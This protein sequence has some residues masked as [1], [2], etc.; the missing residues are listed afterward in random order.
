M[1]KQSFLVICIAACLVLSLVPGV[2][3]LGEEKGWITVYCN[4]EGASVYFDGSYMGAISGGSYTATVYT[5]AT[6][7]KTATVEKSGYTTATSAI[8]MPSTGQTTTIYTT[9]YPIVTPTPVQYGSIFVSSQPSGA[10]IYFNGDYRGL[11]PLTISD[12]WPG[13]YTIRAEKS[14]YQDYS[15]TAYVSSGTQSTVYCPLTALNTAGALY[16]I[17]TPSGSNVYLD[18]AY[19]GTTPVTLNN[20]A[21]GTHILQVD[22]AGYYDW[23]ST[24]EVPAGG[25]RT[26]DATL[27]PMPSATTGWLYVSSSP[28]GASVTLDGNAMGETPSSGSLKLNNIAV[29]THTV[30]LTRPGYQQYSTTTTVSANTVTEVSAILQPTTTSSG[31]GGLSVTST[32]PGANVYIDNAFVGITPLTLSSVATGTHT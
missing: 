25:T 11:S 23:K 1:M 7:Y 12:V 27:N 10:E 28:G 29:G 26:V 3:A 4:I 30:V 24:V 6:P 13:S 9:L 14:G 16:V 8:T 2:T 19:K 31:T 20:L 21:S 5:T 22:H 18:S 15:T 17:S 32:P